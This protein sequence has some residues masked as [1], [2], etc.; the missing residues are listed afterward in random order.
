MPLRRPVLLSI[1]V[2][3]YLIVPPTPLHVM[4]VAPA[5]DAE[6]TATITVT[7]DRPVAGSLDRTVDA[8]RIVRIEPAVDASIG[9]RDPVTIAIRPR[10]PLAADARYTVTVSTAFTAMDGSRLAEPYAFTF[11][12]KGP[13]LVS[14]SPL[15]GLNDRFLQP[16]S[17]FALVYSGPVD[18]GLLSA[19]AYL[20]LGPECGGA[21][22]IRLRAVSERPLDREDPPS[23]RSWMPRTDSLRRVARLVPSAPLPLACSG[24]IVAPTELAAS[25][26]AL[27][28]WSFATYGPLR[29]DSASCGTGRF[30][31]TGPV[32]VRFTTPVRGSEVQRRV[33]ILPAV[34]FTVRDTAREATDWALE[35]TLAPRITY[36]IVTDTALRDIFGQRLEGNPA[37]AVRTT[38]YEPSVSYPY[39]RITVER[40]GF[41]TIAVQHVNV[42]TLVVTVAPVPDS[43]EGEFLR[44]S[45]W[46]LGEMWQKV[47]AGAS[48]ARLPVHA[49]ADRPAVTG[50]RLPALFAGAP[51]HR[52]LLAVRIEGPHPDTSRE[53]AATIAVAQVT[54]L[55]VHAKI[56]AESGVVWVTGASDGKPRAGARV[57]LHDFTGRTVATSVTDARGLAMLGGF[58]ATPPVRAAA[59]PGE[60]GEGEGEGDDTGYSGFEGYVV[61]TLGDDR[62]LSGVSGYDPDLS[63]W[64]FDV[65]PAWGASRVPVAGAVFTERGIYRPGETVHA[66]AIVRTGPLGSLAVPARGDSVR[67]VFD[68][69]DGGTLADTVAQLSSFGTADHV[70]RIPPGAALGDYAVRIRVKRAGRWLDVGWTNYRVAEY[71]PPEFL[72]DVHAD[73][74]PRLPGDTVLAAV[75]ARYLFGAPMARAA[76]A[77]EAR[78]V[79][80]SSWALS[81]PGT[82]GW[83]IGESE[84]WWEGDAPEQVRV[85]ASGTDTLDGSGA[86]TLRVSAPEPE[87]G[88]AAVLTIS[89][90]V[91]DVNRQT[92]GAS[93][94]VT[95]HPASFYL[96]AKAAGTGYFWT[97]GAPQR[98]QVVAVRPGGERVSGARVRVAVARREWHQVH[99]ERDGVA[100]MI[101]EWVTDTVARCT[102]V[103]TAEPRECEVVPPA[104][105]TYVVSLEARDERS[106][107]VSTTFYRWAAGKEWVPWND[108]SRLKVDLIADKSRYSP[109]DTATILVASP[110]TGVEAWLTVEREGII[111]QRRLTLGSGATTLRLPVT[112]AWA[113]NAY[114]SV[115]IARGRAAP[116]GRLDDPGRPT[117]RVGYTEL[118]VTPEVKRLAVSVTPGASEYRPGDTARV[119]VRVTDAGGAPHR[120][121]VTL[122]AVDEGVLALTGYKTPDPIDLLYRERG[123][124]MRLSSN[125][126]NVAPQIPEGEKGRR[127]PGGGGGADRAGVLRSRFQTTAFFLGSVVTGADGEV[128]ATAK[129]PDNLT[130]FRVMAVAVTAGDRYGSGESPML[131]TRP[132]V[133]R[134]ALP[135]FVRAGDELTAGTVVNQRAGGTPRVTVTAS[136][137]GI[138][139]RGDTT[140]TVTL[141]PGRG[142]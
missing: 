21:R 121:E 111:E 53:G 35:A 67:W 29:L 110:F 109:G 11:R 88:R 30:C 96:A 126:A 125:M 34:P 123:L 66:K 86:R 14:G 137:T 37:A 103:T 83:Y 118:R 93:A 31:P 39:G 101:G 89:A 60:E 32:V 139:L 46:S 68:D 36:A 9:W 19:K 22:V 128:V 141:A 65:S 41:G 23:W 7:F 2:V 114:V 71:R 25:Q 100:E 102:V 87:K 59:D 116:P 105:G 82:D 20:R 64:N 135:R 74:A 132:L 113:P 16:R 1:G 48:V 70:L 56:G 142:A 76:V 119:R 78:A 85:V 33:R 69:R 117:I 6:R 131:V 38:G 92:V 5:G 17:S 95:V 50:V 62:A 42:D 124:G 8:S 10:A 52:A 3:A 79:P 73:S 127:S 106:R 61:V 18:L 4:R 44:R 13:T 133:A 77:W 27:T 63:P 94:S 15:S 43:L 130:T 140:R 134:P 97:A 136:A 40:S 138:A 80:V 49:G 58:R 104:G 51:P 72:V 108:E 55:G 122:W 84:W 107:A 47:R 57:T 115:L 91:Q 75:Q 98:V 99:R 81:I 112:E 26:G 120:A 129:L 45:N 90:S 24:E 54:D 28:A 12:V